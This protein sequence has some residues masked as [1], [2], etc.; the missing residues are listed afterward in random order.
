MNQTNRRLTWWFPVLTLIFL[1]LGTIAPLPGENH[2]FVPFQN[3]TLS[4]LILPEGKVFRKKQFPIGYHYQ[5][6]KEFVVERN[7]ALHQVQLPDSIS[8]W[9]ALRNKMVRMVVL[10]ASRDTIP[11]DIAEFAIIGLPLN[12]KGHIWVYPIEEFELMKEMYTWYN[13]FKHN[14]IYSDIAHRFYFDG[15]KNNG[16]LAGKPLSPYDDLIRKY[17][18]TIGWDWRLLASLIFVESNFRMNITSPRGAIGLM[19][20]M[21]ATARNFGIEEDSQL[22]DPEVNIEVGTLLIKE[23]SRQLRD[24]LL[25][26]AE[27][28]KFVLAAYNSGYTQVMDCRNFAEIKGKNP[29]S[30]QDVAEAIPWMREPENAHLVMRSFKGGETIRYVEEVL[31]LYERYCNPGV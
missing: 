8:V 11:E 26:D 20:V 3:D 4:C 10:D 18:K 16:Y 22:Y 13:S 23:I 19:Q 29:N 6:L 17:S 24:S 28:L 25:T 5:I 12:A 30:W 1:S 27:Q 9:E 21:P 7:S 31:S 14:S 2:H 15:G